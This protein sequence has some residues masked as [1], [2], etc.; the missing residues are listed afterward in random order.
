MQSATIYSA[1]PSSTKLDDPVSE[2]RGSRISRIADKSRETMM[3]D[4]DD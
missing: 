3:A 1:K 2:I 4:P